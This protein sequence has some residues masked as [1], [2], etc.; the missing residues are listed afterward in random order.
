MQQALSAARTDAEKAATLCNTLVLPEDSD[1]CFASIANA[2][3]KSQLCL[4]IQDLRARDD[5]LMEFAFKN[6]YTVCNQLSNRYL[7][8][9]CQSLARFSTAQSEQAEAEALAAQIEAEAAAE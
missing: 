1:P 4:N 8:T 3:S 9:S 5:C 6:D 2:S 7:L